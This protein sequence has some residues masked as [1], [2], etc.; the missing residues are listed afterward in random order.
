M[1]TLRHTRTP[2]AAIQEVYGWDEKELTAQ[3]HKYMLDEALTAAQNQSRRPP[4]RPFQ[5]P[6]PMSVY[7]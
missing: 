1:E 4:I 6:R 5:C 2:W 7:S 3:W